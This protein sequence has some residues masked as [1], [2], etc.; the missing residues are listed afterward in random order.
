MTNMRDTISGFRT[1]DRDRNREN[2]GMDVESEVL[3]VRFKERKKVIARYIAVLLSHGFL[4]ESNVLSEVQCFYH[5]FREL[6]E[7]LV[8]SEDLIIGYLDTFSSENFHRLFE[9]LQNQIT[10]CVYSLEEEEEDVQDMLKLSITALDLV[11]RS[12]TSVLRIPIKDFVNESCSDKLHLPDI[13]KQ[14]YQKKTKKMKGFVFLDYPWLFST[15]AKVDVIQIECQFRMENEITNFIDQGIGIE[16][17]Q[18]IGEALSLNIQVRRNFILEDALRMLSTQ[19]KNLKKQLKIKFAGEEGIDQGG[20]KKEFFHLLMK[21]LFNP[22]YAMFEQKFNGRFYWFNKLSM[23][24]NV[25]FELIGTLLALAI[26][27]SV[28]L[29]APFPKVVYKKLLKEKL[30]L[31]DIEEFDPDLY[32]TMKNILRSPEVEKMDLT[33]STSYDNFGFEQVVDLCPGGVS[34]PVT[35]ANKEQ[36]V[37]AYLDWYL[38]T[39]VE[40]Q[41]R[42]FNKGF[43]KV[44]SYESIKLLNSQEV[45]QLICGISELNFKELEETTQYENCS[46]A[47]QMVKWFWEIL[48]SLDDDHKK[49]FLKFT[50]GSDRSPLRG[51][52]ELNLVIMVQGLDD[53][54]LPS[55]HTCFNHLVLP[56]YSTKDFLKAKLLQAIENNEGF[57]LS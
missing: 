19:G 18:F 45:Q 3:S 51:L 5:F 22:N 33:F 42:P 29:P 55:A 52:G 39:S 41:F 53:S 57:G 26:Y 12:N 8:G 50:T 56:K 16:Q 27:N 9:Q 4:W 32:T 37:Q 48:H 25:N 24:C 10:I 17:L 20:V 49:M 35:N 14:Y 46:P 23:E 2:D 47:D 43:Y 44:I 28:L 13:A 7:I 40:Q 38:N 36:F 21:E 54:R 11:H 1:I 15:E 6:L 34:I 30:V 31:E